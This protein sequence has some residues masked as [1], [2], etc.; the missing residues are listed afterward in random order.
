MEDFT[1]ALFGEAEKGDYRTVY[2]CRSLPELLETFGEPPP[3][4]LGLH[5]AVQTLLYKYT[6]YFLR[7][8]EEGFSHMDYKIGLD[9]L[10]REPFY[11]KVK[12]L[13]LPGVGDTKILEAATPVCRKNEQVLILTEKDLYDL[14]TNPL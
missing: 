7:V 13:G 1:I 5:F 8:Q 10:Q 14:L 3:F 9:L 12:A 4:S 2:H 6:V 11:E